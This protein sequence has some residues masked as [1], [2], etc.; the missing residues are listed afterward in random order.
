MRR[1][2]GGTSRG[3]RS[4]HESVSVVLRPH[5]VADAAVV[6]D[7]ARVRPAEM[8]RGILIRNQGDGERHPRLPDL[9]TNENWLS[10]HATKSGHSH[11]PPP[12]PLQ[13]GSCEMWDNTGISATRWRPR[14]NNCISWCHRFHVPCSIQRYGLG[15]S[16]TR[17][18][19]H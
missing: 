9:T 2:G 14:L 11:L 8:E 5:H 13:P 1:G 12:P 7:V 17:W 18:R 15:I 4:T 6:T 16:A 10:R 19:P 3:W